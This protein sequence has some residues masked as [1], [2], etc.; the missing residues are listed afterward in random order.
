MPL[1]G[2]IEKLPFGFSVLNTDVKEVPKGLPKELP[3]ENE[4]TDRK[5]ES[6]QIIPGKVGLNISMTP[7]GQPE[8]IH[9]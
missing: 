4:S 9:L 8:Y 7:S 1:G 5:K 6:R 3:I 2:L